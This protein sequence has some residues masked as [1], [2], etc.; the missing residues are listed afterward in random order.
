M[1][2][3]LLQWFSKIEAQLLIKVGSYKTKMSVVVQDIG[4][5]RFRKRMVIKID[6]L[7][8]ECM[9]LEHV[10]TVPYLADNVACFVS[11]LDQKS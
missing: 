4:I 8:R 1:T 7:F 9:F 2:S 3:L 10:S 5:M 6:I 11:F